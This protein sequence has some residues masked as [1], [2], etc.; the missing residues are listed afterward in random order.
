MATTQDI[1]SIPLICQRALLKPE[2]GANVRVSSHQKLVEYIQAERLHE[3]G[4]TS[5]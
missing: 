3:T 1:Y 5:N 2:T 4:Q